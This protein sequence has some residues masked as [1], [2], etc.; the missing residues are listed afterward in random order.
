MNDKAR[1]DTPEWLKVIEVVAVLLVLPTCFF[2]VLSFTGPAFLRISYYTIVS[3]FIF[4]SALSYL[5]SLSAFS[6]HFFKELPTAQHQAIP[7]VTFIVSAYLPNE[8]EV[9][10]STILNILTKVKRPEAGIEVIVAYNT[11][12]LE[13]LELKLRELVYKWPELI[14]A[15]AFGSKSKSEN[16]NYAL[17]IASGEMIALLD[18][19]HLVM[20]DCIAHAWRWLDEGYA[21]VQGRCQIRNR[22]DSLVTSLVSVEFE[23]IYGVSHHSKSRLY[24]SG[25]FGGSNGYWKASVIKQIRF[26]TD[27]L[28]EDIDATLRATLKGYKIVHDRSIISTELAPRTIK[29]LW[30][31]RKRWAQGWYQCSM[32]YQLPVLAS[33]YLNLRKK[34]LWT[35]LLFW[36]VFYDI[37][38][39][40][41]FPILF[42]YWLY[43]NKINL[44]MNAYIWFALLFTMLSGPFETIVAYKNAVLPRASILKY[45]SY[46]CLTFFYTSFKNFIQIV[47]I[48]DELMGRRDWIISVRSKR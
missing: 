19:D 33:S 6:R 16:L 18:A 14:L 36:R 22:D 31:Q 40:F 20:P 38:S 27:R 23:A 32:K 5:S 3:F 39:H 25:L 7:K 30:Y 47:A 13:P 43:S 28:T 8:I 45:L 1:H 29:G 48:R 11:P 2:W 9:I 34:F 37:V 42:A 44:P 15:N 41:I 26:R 21:A 10:E 17:D 35:T 12:Q 46:G 24:A 4:Q